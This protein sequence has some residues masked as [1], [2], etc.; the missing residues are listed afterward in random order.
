MGLQSAK[1]SENKPVI[2]A[3]ARLPIG[4]K[5]GALASLDGVGL[6]AEVLKK[7]GEAL[8]SGSDDISDVILGNTLSHYGNPARVAAL[9]AGYGTNVPALTI[10]RQCGSGINAVTLAASLSQTQDGIY[11]AGGMESMT[12][13][14]LQLA[15]PRRSFDFT[16]VKPLRRELSTEAVGDPTMG[17][18]AENVARM[19]S[20]SRGEQDEYALR[21][22]ERY[23]RAKE[24]G[25]YEDFVIAME[26]PHGEEFTEDEHPRPDTSIE[27]LSK[28]RPAF[29]VQ[30]T[31]TAG[32]A[33]GLNDG[34]AAVV[35]TGSSLAKERD[36]PVLAEVGRT[37]VSGVDPNT[38]GL[39]PVPAIKELLSR[40][41][42]S[43][44]SYDFIEI[45]EAFAVQTLAC[46]KELGLDVEKVNPNGGA[47]AHGHPIAATGCILVQKVIS[48]L[49]SRGGGS[50]IVSACIGGGQGIATEIKVKGE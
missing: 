29:D 22:Q 46:I 34:A 37:V 20:I 24:L 41:G 36:L 16:S 47:I 8:P 12:H 11:V 28:L 19:F 30:G 6:G 7:L 48:E 33:S 45:N 50:A 21:S 13:E 5:K 10:D 2:T 38:M 15:P 43:I 18:T 14:P 9:K 42:R 4:R 26:L 32:N 1:R 25:K 44:D 27:K 39:G 49:R 17:Q 3:A 35:V 23:Q 31:V 40:T